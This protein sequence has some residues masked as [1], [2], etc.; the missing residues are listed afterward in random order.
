M[1]MESNT[2]FLQLFFKSKI[3]EHVDDT[4]QCDFDLDL[5]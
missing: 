3:S 4:F 2:T 1:V 5:D